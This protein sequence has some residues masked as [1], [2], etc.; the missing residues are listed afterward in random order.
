MGVEIF[1][2]SHCITM[3]AYTLLFVSKGSMT[4][5][6]LVVVSYTHLFKSIIRSRKDTKWDPIFLIFICTLCKSYIHPVCNTVSFISLKNEHH[7]L[8]F[9]KRK[10]T[11][12]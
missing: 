10:I 12:K 7:I 4:D 1:G 5:K 8:N 11:K 2:E 9:Y 3:Y 6:T